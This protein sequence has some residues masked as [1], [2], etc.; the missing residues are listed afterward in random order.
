LVEKAVTALM[1][2][3]QFSCE[4]SGDQRIGESKVWLSAVLLMVTLLT[5][6]S[7]TS[8]SKF[9]FTSNLVIAGRTGQGSV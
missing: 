5:A 3:L 2:F 1:L 4:S 6:V 7:D 8:V 9:P